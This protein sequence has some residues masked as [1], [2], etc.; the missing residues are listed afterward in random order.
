MCISCERATL[1]LLNGTVTFKIKYAAE[2]QLMT[3][4]TMV[5]YTGVKT[6]QKCALF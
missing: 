1:P 5:W 3:K 4:D 6:T 2:A